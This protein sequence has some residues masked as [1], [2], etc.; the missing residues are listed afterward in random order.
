MNGKEQEALNAN[1]DNFVKEVIQQAEEAKK[2]AD[3]DCP[4]AFAKVGG[5]AAAINLGQANIGLTKLNHSRIMDVQTK[6]GELSTDVIG[7]K[8]QVDTVR[9]IVEKKSRTM[10][11]L[12]VPVL[13]IKTQVPASWVGWACVAFVLL[14]IW[15]A[16]SVG[17][18]QTRKDFHDIKQFIG[19]SIELSTN[20]ISILS[21]TARNP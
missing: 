2:L 3:K 9:K 7:V 13:N 11:P 17:I 15:R 18:E 8:G 21:R 10:I 6:I 19:G 20:G 14:S 4:S 12:F 16:H 1:V 5:H